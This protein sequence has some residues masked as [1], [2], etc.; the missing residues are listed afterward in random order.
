MTRG[1]GW[2]LL[3]AGVVCAYAPQALAQQQEA[4]AGNEADQAD[5]EFGLG[6]KAFLA[7]DYERALSHFFASNRLAPNRNVVFNIARAYE[8]MKRYVEAYRYY[9]AYMEVAEGDEELKRGREALARMRGEIALVMVESEPAGARIYVERKELG[10]YGVAPRELALKPGE[11]TLILELPGHEEAVVQRVRAERGKSLA[12]KQALVPREGKLALSGPVDRVSLA[13]DDGEA[14]EVEL[15][16]TIT[17]PLGEHRL[18]WSAPGYEPAAQLVEVQEGQTSPV[19]LALTRQ[20]GALV[21]TA[22]EVGAAIWLDGKLE[23]FS[24]AVLSRVPA[25]AHT[26]EVRREGFTAQRQPIVIEPN[27]RLEITAELV[28]ATEVAAASRQVEQLRDASASVSLISSQ[29]IAAFGYTGTADALRGTRGVYFSND[30]AYTSVGVR[31]FAPFG[32]FGN[33][34]QVLIDGH[35]INDNWL[36]ASYQEYELLSDL[37]GLDRME[38]VRGPVS[39][40]YGSGAFFGVLNLVTPSTSGETTSRVGGTA[41]GDGAVRAYAHGRTQFEG[42]GAQLSVAGITGQAQDYSSPLLGPARRPLGDFNAYTTMGKVNWRGFT[43]QGY[44]HARDAQTPTGAFGSIYG[45]TRARQGDS[46][47]YMSLKWER[48]VSEALTVMARATYDIYGYEGA[49]PYTQPDGGLLRTRFEGQWVGAE[50]RVTL[51]PFQGARWTLGVDGQRHY[52]TRNTS[53]SAVDGEVLNID[54]PYWKSS[55][56]LILAQDLGRTLSVSAGARY[57]AWI[58]DALPSPT[59]AGEEEGRV[60]QSVNPRATV[61]WR[62][63]DQDTVKLMGGRA[64]RAP[65]IYEL[66]FNDGG[67]SQIPSPGLTPET[68]YSGELE[69]TRAL[70][71]RWEVVGGAYVNRI[72]D[73]IEQVGAGDQADPLRYL[74][75]DERLWTGG[76]EAELRRA[77]FRG[78]MASAQYAYQ[79]TRA[80]GFGDVFT[81]DIPIPNSPEHLVGLKLIAPIVPRALTLASRLSVESGRVDRQGD[82]TPAIALV[83]LSA[84]GELVGLPLRYTFGVRN[85]LDARVLHPVGDDTPDVTIRQPGRTFLFDLSASF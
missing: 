54:Y 23:G 43:L 66:T 33:R 19:T 42:G 47:G 72:D 81:S 9:A 38:L 75:A 18:S 76:A 74:N 71:A 10:A 6:A 7:A 31:G 16:A 65:S 49:F 20:V 70:G 40:L 36:G 11:Y 80:G 46:R 51:T 29:E 4:L 26:L 56:H 77:L 3:G 63:S 30:Q 55:A 82:R 24:P 22:S 73:L 35:T 2:A 1:W 83:D 39:V 69:Y 64:F 62:P 61:V 78:W 37:Y 50:T 59:G 85:L 79:R 27:G 17:L 53:E 60:I 8:S 32:Q 21:V 25:G 52:L 12:I 57:D 14:R 34:L 44:Y 41:I 28:A 45:D 5:V 48:P 84:S 13:I 68:I 67:I 58:F 15:P